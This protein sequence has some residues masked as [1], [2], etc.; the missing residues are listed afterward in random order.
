MLIKNEDSSLLEESYED[1]LAT[2]RYFNI[3]CQ[4]FYKEMLDELKK[5]VANRQISS[6]HKDILLSNFIG[7]VISWYIASCEIIK[8]YCSNM[9]DDFF[10]AIETNPNNKRDVRFFFDN[11]FFELYNFIMKNKNLKRYYK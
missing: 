11:K 9:I 2:L 4:L 6:E 8:Q 5:I 10:I 7:D 3:Q 1:K